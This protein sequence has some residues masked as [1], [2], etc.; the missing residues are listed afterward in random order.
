MKTFKRHDH[1]AYAR[2]EQLLDQERLYLDPEVT[3]AYLCRL[4]GASPKRLDGMLR[5]ELGLGGDALLYTYRRGEAE[6][7]TEMLR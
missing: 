4:A 3:F 1:R 2:F 6:R 5:S 7:R